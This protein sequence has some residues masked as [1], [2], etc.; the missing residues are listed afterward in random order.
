[1]ETDLG[2]LKHYATLAVHFDSEKNYSGASYYYIQAASILDNILAKGQ[3]GSHDTYVAKAT[4]YRQR[5]E[6]LNRLIESA[7]DAH[8]SNVKKEKKQGTSDLERAHFLMLE[9]LEEDEAGNS[10]DAVEIYSAAIELC[11]KAK[12][13]TEDKELQSKLT[14]VAKSAL[15]R[16]EKL[17]LESKPKPNVTSSFR[18]IPPLGFE[19][20]NLREG[21]PQ[22]HS[23]SSSGQRGPVAGGYTP[24]EK[25]VLAATSI[26]NGREYLPFMAS[27]DLK[28]RFAFPMP[29]SDKHGKLI[30]SPK[31]KSK[32][33]SWSRPEEFM[34]S[35]SI[36]AVSVDCFSVKQTVVSDC[37]VV[38]SIG[39]AAQYDKK[40]GKRLITSII[41]PQNKSGYPVY[42]P[43]GKYMVKLRLN[44]VSRKVVIDDYL[45]LGPHGEPLCSYSSNR[46]ELWVSLLEKAYLKVMGGYDFPGS[47]SNIDLHALTGWIPERVSIRP[48]DPTFN[49]DGI[50]KK[51]LK[52][53]HDGDVLITVATGEI[54]E[55]EADRAGLVPCHAYAMLDIREVNGVKLLM[56]KN[57]W[58]HLRWKGNYSE[59]DNRHWTPEMRSALNYDP[60]DA[61]NFD[62]GV[63]WIDY[64]SL[65]KFYDVFYMNWNPS[66]FKHTYAVHQTWQAGVGP[67]KDMYNLSHNPQYALEVSPGSGAIWILLTRHIT[68]IEDF[69]NN[70]EYITVLVY[71]NEGKKV[72][73][74]FDPPPYID[75]V[76]INS[77]HYLCQMVQKD[78][79]PQRYSLVI[80]Q[81]EKS[82]TLHFSLR[83]YSTLPFSLKKIEDPC[84]FKKE[85]KGEWSVKNKTAG[86]CGNNRETYADNPRFQIDSDKDCHLI[87][88][89]L[90]PKQYQVGFDIVCVQANDKTSPKYFRTKASGPYRSG[91][92]VLPLEVASGQ[93]DIIPT[94]FRPGQEAKFFLNVHS[95]IPIK[96]GRLK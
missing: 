24:E 71:K 15:D 48:D 75:G 9:A 39:V 81:Y 25:K 5:A 80:S 28:E 17:K 57:P 74:P 23:D 38:A 22:M 30:L 83:V 85:L 78:N 12:D 70:K 8:N 90:G 88:E 33:V 91:Y 76:R 4:E 65:C 44:G 94:T 62:N 60:K 11:L 37:S 10:K 54:S 61:Q 26:I 96:I 52:R 66:L 34:S 42:N 53:F 16:A 73:Y 82:A 18:A 2:L 19:G 35:P 13:K 59:I 67:A 50:F 29:F 64:D 68:D 32:L 40:F 63:F 89:L 3:V 87:I 45:P 69:K 21:P 77:P 7:A 84:S 79:S 55:A 27:V 6:T 72:F 46:N 47:N 36:I 58:S 51:L 49:K 41:F 93:Y 31:Q 1:M 92:V 14:T 95:S 20:L 86:G 56:L 43:C